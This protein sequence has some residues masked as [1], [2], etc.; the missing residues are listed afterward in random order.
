MTLNLSGEVSSPGPV[1]G[2]LISLASPT[3]P[4]V[5][6]ATSPNAQSAATAAALI[7]FNTPPASPV[8]D[9][10]SAVTAPSADPPADAASPLNNSNVTV[11]HFSEQR[12]GVVEKI[13]VPSALNIYS[14]ELSSPKLDNKT[15]A[16]HNVLNSKNPFINTGSA[17]S[18]PTTVTATVST[19]PFLGTT[20]DEVADAENN[21]HNHSTAASNGTGPEEEEKKRTAT[22]ERKKNPFQDR[23][24][25]ADLVAAAKK[26]ITM[27]VKEKEREKEREKEKANGKK[28]EVVTEVDG[29]KVPEKIKVSGGM[30][31]DVQSLFIPS[32]C[33]CVFVVFVGMRVVGEE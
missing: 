13:S 12:G 29:G 2:P 33:C 11:T 8:F 4:T 32:R 15:R 20:S 1:V 26:A 14:A 16:Q 21:N 18:S 5:N 28:E 24:I 9:S 27:S 10:S 23:E 19:N 31:F 30:A 22:L 25:A 6:G 3:T 7:T 17:L